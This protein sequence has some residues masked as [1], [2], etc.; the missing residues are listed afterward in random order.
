V[1]NDLDLPGISMGKYEYRL[2]QIDFD[3]S[4][5][6]STEVEVEVTAPKKFSL[7]QNYP[8][9]FNPVTNIDYQIPVKG[10]VTL[11]IFNILG[12]E[13]VELVNEEMSAGN[14][15]VKFDGSRLPSGVYIYHLTAGNFSDSK[16]LILVK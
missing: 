15:E 13:V 4:Y 16:K 12:E 9:P 11:K 1:N 14:Y 3:G 7:E 2:K 5:N 10:F 8:N 6:Y